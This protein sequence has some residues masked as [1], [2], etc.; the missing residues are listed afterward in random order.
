M[1]ARK[2]TV[3]RSDFG[4]SGIET[5]I[6]ME[7]TKQVPRAL[8]FSAFGLNFRLTNEGKCGWRLI[9]SREK[10]FD[11][12]G[13]AQ[14]LS[15]FLSEKPKGSPKPLTYLKEESF[16]SNLKKPAVKR[17]LKY[18]AQTIFFCLFFVQTAE[19]IL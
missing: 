17:V 18:T 19:R 4:C 7:I 3:Y 13:A 15:R 16:T 12:C 6:I 11:T 1:W 5:E 14:A 8:Y 10:R 9:T 2:I